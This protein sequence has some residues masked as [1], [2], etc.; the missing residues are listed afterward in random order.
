[1]KGVEDHWFIVFHSLER[2]GG[3]RR[4]CVHR[5]C[6]KSD[7]TPYLPGRPCEGHRIRLGAEDEDDEAHGL[8]AKAGPAPSYSGDGGGAGHAEQKDKIKHGF[9][10]VF[11]AL[12]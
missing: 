5:V 10:K 3:A 7:G 2:E 4:T 8:K 12:K 9:Q 1:M 6:W 11:N